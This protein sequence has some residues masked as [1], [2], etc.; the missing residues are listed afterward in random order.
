MT[1]QTGAAASAPSPPGDGPQRVL[2]VHNRYRIH[3]GEE[4]AVDLHVAALER[5]GIPHRP[6]LRDSRTAGPAR[7]AAALLRG[8]DASAEVGAAAAEFG[9]TVVHFHNMQPLFGPRA[10]T[11]AQGAGAAV[12]LHLHNFRLFCAIGVSFRF[13]E[14]CFRCRG[15][16]TLPGAVL[17]C[18]GDVAESALYATALSLH[19]PTVFEAVDRFATPSRYAAGQLARLGVPAHSIEVV[20]SYLPETALTESSRADRGTFGLVAGRLSVEKG[21]EIAIDAS[22]RAGIPLKVAG[23]GPLDAVLR[24]RV[25]RVGAPVELLGR[26]GPEDLGRLLSEAAFAVV[27]SLGAEVFPFAALEAMAAGLPVVASRTG[28]LPELVGE[29]RCV[30]RGDPDALAAA[31]TALWDEPERRR[32]EGDEMVARARQRFG[33]ARFIGD[34]GRLYARVT[35]EAERP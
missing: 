12:V 9:A 26:V 7:A 24:D 34:L 16:L 2:V 21:I 8:G 5:A 32:R 15:R 25:A 22:A 1:D 10:L 28:G 31:M 27:P 6:L 20:P 18:R 35:R 4:R 29:E 13:G 11:A 17:N 19:Q 30:R 14:P 23:D 3:G 33:E